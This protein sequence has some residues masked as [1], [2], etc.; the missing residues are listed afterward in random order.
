MRKLRWKNKQTNQTKIKQNKNPSSVSI[1]CLVYFQMSTICDCLWL[2]QS[3]SEYYCQPCNCTW[4]YRGWRWPISQRS[5]K[6]GKILFR[7]F[8]YMYIKS[9]LPIL[10]ISCIFFDI[11]RA[12]AFLLLKWLISITKN[13]QS[14]TSIRYISML[15]IISPQ[16]SLSANDL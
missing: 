9:L 8:H 10:N 15:L 6:K 4:S 2:C 3:I 12:K 13:L 5:Y 7:D 11:Y 14:L 1:S 16:N